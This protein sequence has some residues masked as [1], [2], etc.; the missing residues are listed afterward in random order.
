M[1]MKVSAEA[2]H[3]THATKIICD[4]PISNAVMS[5]L[6]GRIHMTIPPHRLTETF[7]GD[8]DIYVDLTEDEV[9]TLFLECFPQ[10]RDVMARHMSPPAQG[11]S[12]PE[13]T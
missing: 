1:E 5:K 2:H 8:Y 4:Y 9:T 6:A 7:N 13:A 10:V 3:R 12:E 11:P